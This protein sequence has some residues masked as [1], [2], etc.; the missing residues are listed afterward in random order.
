MNRHHLAHEGRWGPD[1]TERSQMRGRLGVAPHGV[2]CLRALPLRVVDDLGAVDAPVEVGRDE[3][4][5]ITDHL[6]GCLLP[7]FGES[8]LI[9]RVDGEDVD[10]GYRRGALLDG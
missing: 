8:L 4:G 2:E 5:Q 1:L 3:S 10:E 7:V 6:F 9:F